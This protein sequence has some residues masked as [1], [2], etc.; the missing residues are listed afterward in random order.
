[1][2]HAPELDHNLG[3][4]DHPEQQVDAAAAQPG[5]LPD[6]QAAVGA[7]QDQGAVASMDRVGQG[8]DLGRVRNR[9]SSRST[10]GSGTRRHGDWPSMPAST[11]APGTYQELVGLLDRRGHRGISPRI[12]RRGVESSERLGRHRGGRSA[13]LPD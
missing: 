13:A 11:A 8:G 6:A 1:V 9:I 7:G 5:Q 12:T 10:L 2:Q 3:H 4:R